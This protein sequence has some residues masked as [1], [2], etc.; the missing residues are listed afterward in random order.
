MKAQSIFYMI[1]SVLFVGL[2]GLVF[3]LSLQDKPKIAN[4][5]AIRRS[6]EIQN[7]RTISLDDEAIALSGNPVS[8]ELRDMAFD[9][10]DQINAIRVENG[11]NE[12]IWDNNLET[13]ANV[14]S[15]EISIVF[16]HTRPNGKAWYTVNSTIQGGENLAYGFSTATDVVDGWMDSPSHRDNILYDEFRTIAISV[17]KVDG[18]YYWAQAFGY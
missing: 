4:E 17:Y 15:K 3:A 14:R 8:S 7:D 11:L 12:L 10:F 13:V 5:R 6:L 9:A 16:S 18:N 2:V 1:V